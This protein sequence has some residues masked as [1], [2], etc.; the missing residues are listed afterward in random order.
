[1]WKAL[2]S[3]LVLRKVL[4]CVGERETVGDET[5][6]QLLEDQVCQLMVLIEVVQV[7]PV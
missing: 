5:K 1:M 2:A 4:L 6:D 7:F 3:E